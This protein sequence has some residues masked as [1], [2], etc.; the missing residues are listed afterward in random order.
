MTLTLLACQIDVPAMTERHEKAAHMNRVVRIIDAFLTTARAD[1]VVLPELCS[2]DY[3]RAAFSH[4]DALAEPLDGETSQAFAAL[5]ARH[6]VHVV[7]GLPRAGAGQFFITQVVIGPDG[8]RIGHYDKIHIAQFGAS[9]EKKFFARGDHLLAFDIGNYRIAPIICYDIRVPELTRTLA[10]D[11]GVN[12]ILHCGVY[13]RDE[14][15]PSWHDFAVTRAMENQVYLLSLSRAGAFY[16]ESIFCPP[17]ID[18]DHRATV[19]GQEET[20]RAFDIEFD[21]LSDARARYP[22]LA[23]RL[24]DYRSLTVQGT[25]S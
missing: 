16:G 18:H 20:L 5:A 19:L 8:N 23:D 10:V 1:I 14:S 24:A 4:L 12:V 7:F 2:I 25:R 3:S 9:M 6:G 17:W 11:H 13:A 22:F 21:T 15:F